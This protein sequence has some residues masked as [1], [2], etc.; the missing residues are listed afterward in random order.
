M[1]TSEEESD[2]EQR[3]FRV[4]R[5][6]RL[7]SIALMGYAVV[8]EL[9]KPKEQR[10]WHGALFGWLPYDLRPP[11]PAR[12]QAT[13]WAPDDERLIMPRAFGVGWSPNLGR[14]VRLVR[15]RVGA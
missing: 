6:I 7:V 11:T 10:T 1:T 8:E 2:Q 15:E 13:L 9:R 3:R 4:R 5:I 12:I 14:I